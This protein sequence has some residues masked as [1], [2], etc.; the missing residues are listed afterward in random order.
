MLYE[1]NKIKPVKYIQSNYIRKSHIGRKN[2]SELCLFDLF[3][4]NK[5]QNYIYYKSNKN[6]SAVATI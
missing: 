6:P 2:A 5:L 3:F 1:G 4:K